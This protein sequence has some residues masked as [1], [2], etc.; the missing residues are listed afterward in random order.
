MDLDRYKLHI[1]EL[2]K[3]L[4]IT[5]SHLLLLVDADEIKKVCPHFRR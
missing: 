1:M 4:S 5:V 3:P 2:F